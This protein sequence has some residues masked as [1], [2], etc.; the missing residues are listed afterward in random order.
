MPTFEQQATEEL[1]DALRAV[2]YRWHRGKKH[3]AGRDTLLRAIAVEEGQRVSERVMREAIKH[4]RRDGVLICSLPGVDGGYYIAET[5]QE[6]DEFV[7]REFAAKIAD[8]SETLR[9][10]Q[11]SARA[12][13]EPEQPR[14]I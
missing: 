3:A 8:M 7:Q 4:L 5:A 11:T 12:T 13:F 6:F 14:L 10:M 1:K 9:R 2:L